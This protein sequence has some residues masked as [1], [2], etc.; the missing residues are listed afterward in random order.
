VLALAAA[1]SAARNI[2]KSDLILA[3]DLTAADWNIRSWSYID[4]LLDRVRNGQILIIKFD[5]YWAKALHYK[6]VLSKPVMQWG[7]KQVDHWYGTGWGYLDHFVGT[8]PRRICS[9][10]KF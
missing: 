3:G 9:I 7:G 2:Q 1:K 6:G 5:K 8:L 4:T 10:R